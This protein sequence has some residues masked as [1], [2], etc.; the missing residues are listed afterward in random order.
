M[1]LRNLAL[2][3]SLSGPAFGAVDQALLD[4]VP[5]E[6]KILYG[7]DV[8]KS[9]ASP[10]GR[11]IT[12]RAI[13]RNPGLDRLASVTGFDLKRD[14][15]EVIFVSLGSSAGSKPLHYQLTLARGTFRPDRLASMANLS[16]ATVSMAGS[17]QVIRPAATMAHASLAFLDSSTLIMGDDQTIRDVLNHRPA[18][19]QMTPLKR[20]AMAISAQQDAWFATVSPLTE[21]GFSQRRGLPTALLETF[22]EAAG[23]IRFSRD[24][25]AIS[26]QVLAASAADAKNAAD[27]LKAAVSLIRNPNTAVLKSAQISADASTIRATLELPERGVERLFTPTTR[28]SA[29]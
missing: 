21:L 2:L 3:A 17:V 7:V 13:S 9:L 19:H 24:S 20:K 8:V 23:G 14:L 22:R 11:Q 18:L 26:A 5:A 6:A 27:A 28:R 12:A 16:G 29:K 1:Q 10:F 25:I 15:R 4:L